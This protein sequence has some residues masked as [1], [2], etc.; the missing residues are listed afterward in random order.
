[1]VQCVG[2]G[3]WGVGCG[4]WVVGCEVWGVEATAATCASWAAAAT[5]PLSN[6]AFSIACVC[7]CVCVCVRERERVCVCV[8][9]C[10]CACACVHVWVWVCKRERGGGKSARAR[11]P[12]LRPPWPVGCGVQEGV[13]TETGG[14]LCAAWCQGA[15]CM[16]QGSGCGEQGVGL[17]LTSIAAACA[18]H[19]SCTAAACASSISFT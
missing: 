18:V 15:R 9:V 3:V 10:V 16:V 8:C 13:N 5:R 17:I 1:M 6:A 14:G 7:V 19:R 12:M 4:V 2:C 11:S